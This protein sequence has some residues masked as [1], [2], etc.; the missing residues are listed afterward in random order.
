MQIQISLSA[1]RKPKYASDL[2]L[3]PL[4]YK[5]V[6]GGATTRAKIAVELAKVKID[7]RYQWG[8]TA[9]RQIMLPQRVVE[10][11]VNPLAKPNDVVI[12]LKPST[13][14]S[15]TSSLKFAHSFWSEKASTTQSMLI[16][17]AKIPKE[18]CLIYLPYFLKHATLT[19]EDYTRVAKAKKKVFMNRMRTVGEAEAIV[20]NTPENTK[21]LKK[22]IVHL[23]HTT[24]KYVGITRKVKAAYPTVTVR[25]R[26][27]VVAYELKSESGNRKLDVEIKAEA[28]RG[29]VSVLRAGRYVSF[30]IRYD[31]PVT[32]EVFQALADWVLSRKSGEPPYHTTTP[33][34]RA[35]SAA[36]LARRSKL[37]KPARRKAA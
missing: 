33:L 32:F 4:I 13:L 31:G 9:Y 34:P 18:D 28:M 11:A 26:S 15:W 23:F 10:A 5:W 27:E 12:Q 21:I 22:Q 3:L 16:V 30:D 25:K 6:Q 37:K 20:R 1:A 17:K 19:D 8:G 14:S 7:P 2:E 24:T 36:T 29:R 35:P